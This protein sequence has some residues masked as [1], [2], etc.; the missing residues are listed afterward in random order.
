MVLV[1]TCA[2]NPADS[3]IPRAAA[4]STAIASQTSFTPASRQRVHQ[5]LCAHLVATRHAVRLDVS[6]NSRLGVA[7]IRIKFSKTDPFGAGRVVRIV[8]SGG[9]FC[10]YAALSRFSQLR[11]SYPGPFLSMQMARCSHVGA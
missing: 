6:F 10:P 2:L 3:Y 11:G 5:P 7:S 1:A 8:A 4:L 9:A